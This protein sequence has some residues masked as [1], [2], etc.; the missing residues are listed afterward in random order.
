MT[1]KQYSALVSAAPDYSSRAA[2]VA[3][4]GDDAGQIWDACTRSVKDILAEAGLTQAK[5]CERFCLPRRTVEDWYSGRRSC[6][7]ST[8]L[9]VQQLLGLLNVKI[10]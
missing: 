10:D 4:F 6:A 2:F 9:M 3:A 1:T 7:L 5:F 8:R